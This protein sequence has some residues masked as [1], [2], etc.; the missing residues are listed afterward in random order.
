MKIICNNKVIDLDKFDTVTCRE[1]LVGEGFPIEAVRREVGGFFWRKWKNYGR[2]MPND[3]NGVCRGSFEK[4]YWKLD[5]WRSIHIHWWS[6]KK[7]VG[8]EATINGGD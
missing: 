7:F 6:D 1:S 2:N 3:K 8:S 4:D 5:K